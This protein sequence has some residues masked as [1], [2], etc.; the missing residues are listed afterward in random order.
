MSS[1]NQSRNQ[2][3]LTKLLLDILR[4]YTNNKL[5]GVQ[6]FQELSSNASSAL[7]KGE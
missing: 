1:R 6:K 5:K 3:E 7:E 4:E 2:A